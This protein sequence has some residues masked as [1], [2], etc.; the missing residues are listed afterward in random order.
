MTRH[1]TNSTEIA[2]LLVLILLSGCAQEPNYAPVYSH[3]PEHSQDQDQY[4]SAD[5]KKQPAK[6]DIPKDKI[7]PPKAVANVPDKPQVLAK[8]SKNKPAT[9]AVSNGNSAS[10]NEKKLTISID[11]EKVLKLNFQWPLKGKVVKKF[12]QSHDK[13]IE[14]A[15]K[16]GQ[17]VAATEAGKV[18]YSGQGLLGY[19]NLLIIKHNDLYLS[20]YANNSRLLVAE[21]NSVTKGQVIAEVGQVGTK[22]PALHFEIRKNG[23]PIDPM[24]FLSSK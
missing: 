12:S 24:I 21:G 16:V 13:G 9:T 7:T 3:F 18:V 17:P 8:K 14:I 6:T 10:S 1:I 11:K 20:A 19:G 23:K 2:T 15:G 4:S 5:V 22:R